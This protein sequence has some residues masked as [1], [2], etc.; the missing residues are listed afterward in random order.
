MQIEVPI[1]FCVDLYLRTLSSE[2]HKCGG[3]ISIQ[4]THA[5]NF[6]DAKVTKLPLLAPSKE[7][8]SLT[9]LRYPNEMTEKDMAGNLMFSF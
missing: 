9:S 5:G 6:S 8:F 4:L 3:K 2:I 7:V 1:F